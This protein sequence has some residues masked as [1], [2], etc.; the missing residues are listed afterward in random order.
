MLNTK[1]HTKMVQ[2]SANY[3][4][5]RR[6]RSRSM[7]TSSSTSSS[8]SSMVVAAAILSIASIGS[9]NA[10]FVAPST[11]PALSTGKGYLYSSSSRLSA[12]K[13]NNNVE[14]GPFSL[15]SN[16]FSS[17]TPKDAAQKSQL[18]KNV[19]T[20]CT[21]LGFS[22][23][24]LTNPLLPHL[25]YSTHFASA[26]AEDELYAKYGDKGLDTSLVDKDCL[27]N[28]CSL[29]AKACLQDDPDCRKVVSPSMVIPT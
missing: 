15:F 21:T 20:L 16:I 23:L 27:V 26:H 8:S 11:R 18:E 3:K 28:K 17:A 22:A 25:P 12:K 9:S 5:N 6:R 24:F 4:N 14:E 1:H 2:T 7:M 19:A 29:Q 13:Q 10:D